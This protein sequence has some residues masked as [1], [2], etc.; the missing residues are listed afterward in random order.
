MLEFLQSEKFYL[1]II[2]IVLGILIYVIVSKTITK[3]NNINIKYGGKGVDKRK[4]TVIALIKN[5][6]KYVIAILVIILILGVY[7]VDTTSLV[8]SLGVV[9]LVVG[10][11]F[12]DIIKDFLA[13][14]FLIFDNA[15]A[16]GDVVEINGFKGEVISLGLK[17]TKI[18]AYTG[19][20]KILANS[21]FQEVIN[22]N[23]NPS[24][25]LIYVPVGYE[26]EIEKIE[27]ILENIKKEIVKN[28][29]V[30]SMDLLGVDEFKDSYISY[31]IV[32]ECAS[33]THFGIKRQVLKLI[34]REFDKE[35]IEIPYN[36]LD[37]HIDKQSQVGV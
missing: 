35:G 30:R 34:K 24:K 27:E 22:Y 36:Q 11:A 2:Y 10:L 20:V 4:N 25:I 14:V 33:M 18:Q 12:Q 23:L 31:A 5:I 17:T 21:C 15:Y 7:G 13:G 16:V 26:V 3:V 37:V 9:S 6:I 32:V 28:K 8:A 19:E 1:P 29:D